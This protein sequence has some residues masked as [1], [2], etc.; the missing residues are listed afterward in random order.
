[1]QAEKIVKETDPKYLAPMWAR[2]SQ[3]FFIRELA[4]LYDGN[5][6]FILR[7][8]TLDGGECAEA[9]DVQLDLTVSCTPALYLLN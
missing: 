7:F 9:I 4:R 8:F 2:G 6:V 1:M 3:H 5:L